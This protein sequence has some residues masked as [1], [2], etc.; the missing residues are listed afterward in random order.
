MKEAKINI[1]VVTEEGDY[2]VAGNVSTDFK[3]AAQIKRLYNEVLSE[4]E[5]VKV[6]YKSEDDSVLVEQDYYYPT[7]N[8]EENIVSIFD[9]RGGKDMSIQLSA[10]TDMIF[11]EGNGRF[12]YTITLKLHSGKIIFSGILE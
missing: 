11:K 6:K 5:L 9:S 12:D 4:S 1:R 2:I 7:V 3:L 8:I 10:I